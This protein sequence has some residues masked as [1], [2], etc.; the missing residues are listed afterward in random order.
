MAKKQEDKYKPRA[1]GRFHTQ[2][3]TGKHDEDG[4]PIRIPLY[5]KS[6]KELEKLVND[7]KYELEHG[8]F[9]HDKGLTFEDYAAKWFEVCKAS[10][11]I[12]TRAMYKNI[13]DNHIDYLKNKKLKNITKSD[14]QLQINKNNDKPRICEIQL[15]TIKQILETAVDDGLIVKNPC[16]GIELPRRVVKEK[17]PLTEIEKNALKESKLSDLEKAFIYILYG[18]GLRPGEL[19]ALTRKDV[20]IKNKELSINKSI[21]FEGKNPV[22]VFPKTN[23]GIRI[24]PI[25]DITLKVLET[26]LNNCSSLILFSDDNGNYRTKSAYANLYNQIV[27]KMKETLK[28]PEDKKDIQLVKPEINNLTPYV[29]RHNYCTE[30][31]YSDVSLKEAQR[32]MGHA[33]YGM[34]M[35]VYSHLDEK[36]ENTKEKL[37]KIVL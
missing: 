3:S 19:Y 25:P 15:I 16:K 8:S 28:Q 26:Y 12:Q 29:F 18:C 2:V 31:Y 9:A 17:R 37:N 1:D 22:V 5:A 24:I 11:G 14:I 34:I 33:D 23:S 13:I 20:D 10:R 4:K 27:N 21:T 36:K 30:L 35:K 7:T 32:L 6:S